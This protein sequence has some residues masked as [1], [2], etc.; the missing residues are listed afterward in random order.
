MCSDKNDNIKLTKNVLKG[1]VRVR[2]VRLRTGRFGVK[3]Q[4][5]HSLRLTYAL[6]A[7]GRKEP[8]M[9]GLTG[10]GKPQR[11]PRK[12]KTLAHATGGVIKL[13]SG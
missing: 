9:D 4:E 13:S 5:Q 1:S 2:P 8:S 12:S 3:M 11:S 10:E 7:I 6:G